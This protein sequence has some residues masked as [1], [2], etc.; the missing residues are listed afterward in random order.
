[1]RAA[2]LNTIEQGFLRFQIASG[3]EINAGGQTMWTSRKVTLLRHGKQLT[4]SVK[5]NETK[6]LAW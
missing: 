4:V 6:L 5:A 1:M 3:V 2:W